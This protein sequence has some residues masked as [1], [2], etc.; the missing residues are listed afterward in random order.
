MKSIWFD[1]I[2]YDRNIELGI[3]SECHGCSSR[4]SQFRREG[5]RWL[6]HRYVYMQATGESPE[7]VMHLCDNP[8]CINLNHLKGGTFKDNSV[9]MK[10]KGRST[11]G[12][13]HSNRVLASDEVRRIRNEI[14]NGSKSCDVA[15]KYDISRQLVYMIKSGRIW[16]D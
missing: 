5:K 2:S 9:D 8:K 13:S 10:L 7:V 12:N 15:R 3:D 14:R 6:V 11:L 4:Y 1:K 16:S